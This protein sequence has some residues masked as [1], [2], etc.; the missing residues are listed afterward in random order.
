MLAHVARLWIVVWCCVGAAACNRK[1]PPPP[2]VI[3]QPVGNET[4]NGTERIGWD[5]R[6]ADAVELA[7]IGYAIYVDGARAPLAAAA[8][9]PVAS[10]AGFPCS[11]P[12]P[13]L[14]SGPH[15]LQL[16]SF[17]TDGAVLESARSAALGVT[18][19]PATTAGRDD[20]AATRR[21]APWP[22]TVSI[23]ADRITMRLELVADGLDAPADL[24]FAPDGRLFIA[25]H[26]G[27]LRIVRDGRLL[28]DAAASLSDELGAD[29]ALLAL[30]VDPQFDRTHFVFAIYTAASRAGGRMFCLARFREASDTLADRVVLL[31]G[32]PASS[33][34]RASLR[35]GPDAKLYAAFDDGGD[36]RRSGDM[37]SAN[38][39]ILR[40]NADGTTPDD[41]SGSMPVYAE[42]YR[43]PGG[44]GWDPRSGA[45][46]AADR[47]A[48][49][50]SRLRAVT[51][52]DGE[53]GRKK[54]AVVLR[55]YLL[56]GA[57]ASSVAF[58]SGRLIPA[59]AGGLLVASDEGR[60]V[61]LAVDP[62]SGAPAM[63]ERL[64]EDAGGALR[65]VAVGPEGGVYFATGHAVGR[66]VSDVR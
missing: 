8:C 66:L 32:I 36:A 61:R 3:D 47:V 1:S 13:A 26:G 19:V 4:V 51:Q 63:P 64:L 5:Q 16:S 21:N 11:A 48:A 10:A 39:K 29:G 50:A 12:L 43:S 54:R 25:L 38:G 49:R 35:F 57:T 60:L 62:S 24:A 17:V 23:A 56:P 31:D 40:L 42:G 59:L 58:Y 34:P 52:A 27:Q 22:G 14:A 33:S 15:T 44:I 6:A 45:L 53:G 9:A 41:Q 37:A 20:R 46:W 65:A 7:T 2:P 30:A 55:T 28:P 18:V